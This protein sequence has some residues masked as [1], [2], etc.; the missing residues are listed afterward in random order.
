MKK[1]INFIIVDL[2]GG[3][4]NQLF[5]LAFG[6][7]LSAK[8]NCNLK[9]DKSLI[10]FGSNHD[11]KLELQNFDFGLRNF[12]I[13][14]SYITKIFALPKIRI[15]EKISGKIIMA[16]RKSIKEE[17]LRTTKI[18]INKRFSGYFQDWMYADY[19]FLKNYNF[20]PILKGKD[21]KKIK[22]FQEYN[23]SN[24]ILI[25]IRLGDYLEFSNIYEILPEQ[26]F[27]SA[28][29][30]L[31][32]K[33]QSRPVWLVVENIDQ[34]RKFY[35]NLAKL[36]VKFV[37]KDQD[38]KDHEVFYL[39]ARSNCLIASNSTFSLWASWFVL[40]SGGDV[41]VPSVF[42]VAGISSKLIDQRWNSIDI[43]DFT[44]IPKRDLEVIR[45]ENLV[46]FNDLFS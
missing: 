34:V 43:S 30:N 22:L 15:L 18:E 17:N 38:L 21:I 20:L 7:A 2:V 29:N 44:F 13:K 33:H 3:L 19:L 1:N 26:Y 5:G 41:I 10:H 39:M 42:K 45:E 23:L 28:L 31:S 24:P 35:P 12:K 46:R 14:Q 11:R 9:L 40:N 4:G 27:L 8:F 36:A 25:H 6:S 16:K 37:D 32:E